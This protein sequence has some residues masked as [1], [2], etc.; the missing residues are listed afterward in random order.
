MNKSTLMRAFIHDNRKFAE[1][2]SIV[3]PYET[4]VV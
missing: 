3:F 4:F 1:Y 2:D